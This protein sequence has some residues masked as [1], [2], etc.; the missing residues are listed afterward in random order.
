MENVR[1]PVIL[2]SDNNQVN[3]MAV[4]MTS[5]IETAAEGTFYDFYCFLSDNVT[6]ENR[7]LVRACRC[8]RKTG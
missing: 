6:P 3:A 2:S 8:L 4:V 7:D 5:A 1:I